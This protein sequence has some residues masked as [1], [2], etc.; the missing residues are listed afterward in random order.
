[1]AH[2]IQHARVEATLPPRMGLAWDGQRLG[3]AGSA[4]GQPG[5][6]ASSRS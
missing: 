3:V 1:M 6:A 4:T 2:D 5:E